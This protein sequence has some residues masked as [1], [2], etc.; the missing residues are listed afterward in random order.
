LSSKIKARSIAQFAIV[1]IFLLPIVWMVVAALRPTGTALPRT[2][3]FNPTALSLSSFKRVLDLA[4]FG[5]FTLNSLLVVALAVPLTLLISSWAG[6]GMARLPRRSQ[7][8][9]LVLSLAVLMVPGMA[10]W[11]SRFIVYKQLG[12]LDSIWALIAPAWMGT[13]PF[14]ILMFYRAFRRVPAGIYDAARID[15]AGVLRTWSQVAL[16]IA[17]PTA[18]AV[19]LLSFVFYWGDFISPFLY[20][21]SESRYTLPAALQLLQELNRSDWPLLMA[22]AVLTALIPILLFFIAQPYFS[23]IGSE[24]K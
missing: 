9:W 10:L 2:L 8:R 15:G 6:F 11:S 23:R 5:R 16:P 19:A 18:V 4:P 24:R 13:S 21:R 22:A 14:F 1:L 7:R 3:Q 12:W 17:R 20:L